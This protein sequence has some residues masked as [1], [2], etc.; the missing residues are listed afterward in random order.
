ME[1]T[2]KIAV[3]GSRGYVGGCIKQYLI[4]KGWE[5][6]EMS[7]FAECAS[8]GMRF[9]LGDEIDPQRLFGIKT[10]IHCAY[11]FTP[12]GWT[13]LSEVNVRGSQKLF[14]AAKTA[15]IKQIIF[16]S[17]FAAYEG[18]KSLYGKAKLEIEKN[19]LAMG[20]IVIRP[21]LVYGEGSG[22]MFGKLTAQIQKSSIIPLIGDGSQPVF[23]VHQED[24]SAFVEKALEQ[25]LTSSKKIIT[26]A[27][28]HPW[29][30]KELILE[31]AH[32]LNKKILLI[33]IPWRLVWVVL[34]L[35]E[36]CG[37]RLNFRS[38][39]LL[40]FIHQNPLP[41]FSKDEALDFSWRSLETGKMRL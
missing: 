36:A 14:Q 23:L 30:F 6:F 34:K 19:A 27:N 16:V 33:P 39:S 29:F 7:R 28:P 20:A 26:A 25:K 1:E 8:N 37:L 32:G 38:D 2:K 5:I 13:S 18:C 10:L 12:L 9:S 4:S 22:G 11:D 3:T 41:D 40:S 15:G 35:S 21:G 24:L 17:S 31:V